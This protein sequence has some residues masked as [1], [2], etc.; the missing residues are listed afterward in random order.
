M[1]LLIS[2]FFS[3]SVFCF[4]F[5]IYSPDGF[6]CLYVWACVD[7]LEVL[8]R[9]DIEMDRNREMLFEKKEEDSSRRESVWRGGEYKRMQIRC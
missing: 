6:C 8:S 7:A 9:V 1:N 2:L 4:V 5:Y 3:P